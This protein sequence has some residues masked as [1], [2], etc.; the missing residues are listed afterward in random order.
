[1]MREERT[2]RHHV[3]IL[4]RMRDRGLLFAQKRE[5]TVQNNNKTDIKRLPLA[6]FA[7]SG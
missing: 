4:R 5:Q 2:V 1:M 3:E 6:P 7:M